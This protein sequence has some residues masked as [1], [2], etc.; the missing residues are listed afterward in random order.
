MLL[1]SQI[2]LRE[3]GH[4][5]PSLSLLSALVFLGVLGRKYPCD[6]ASFFLR[7]TGRQRVKSG[8]TRPLGTP[9][10]LTLVLERKKSARLAL[11]IWY[12]EMTLTPL[13][14]WFFGEY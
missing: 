14:F 7:Q 1:A 5:G 13:I 4:V 12:Q 6:P 2:R 10:G 8:A 3:G 11:R 9:G